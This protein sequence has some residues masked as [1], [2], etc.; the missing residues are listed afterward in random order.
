[1]AGSLCQRLAL[2]KVKYLEKNLDLYL[3]PNLLSVLLA[4]AHIPGETAVSE[5]SQPCI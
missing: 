3:L 5:T 1:M 2:H 4:P